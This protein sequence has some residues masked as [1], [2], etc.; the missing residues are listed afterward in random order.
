MYSEIKKNLEESE[1]LFGMAN[2]PGTKTNLRTATI[3]SDGGGVFRK[4]KDKLPQ[5]KVGI[6][7]EFLV[8]LSLDDELKELYK[9]RVIKKSEDKIINLAKEYIKRNLD[10]FIKHYNSSAYEYDDD[11]LKYDLAQRGYYKQK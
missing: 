10:L 1:D 8:S 3:W 11:D 7:D 6:K 9:A 2:L 4:R 5:I